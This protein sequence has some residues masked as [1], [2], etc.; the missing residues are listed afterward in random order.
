MP[1]PPPVAIAD[2]GPERKSHPG[3]WIAAAVA[4]LLL[5]SGAY[6]WFGPIRF[7]A[8]SDGAVPQRVAGVIKEFPVDTGATVA[9]PSIVVT[10][11]LRAKAAAHPAIPNS[12]PRSVTPALLAKAGTKMT[13]A[14][15]QESPTGPAVN[16]SVIEKDPQPAIGAR[17]IANQIAEGGGSSVRESEVAVQSPAGSTYKGWKL[18]SPTGETYVLDKQNAPVL[19]VIYSPDTAGN[20]IADRL[21]GNVGNGQGLLD[22]PD[23]R[24]AIMAVP[25]NPPGFELQDISTYNTADLLGPGLQAGLSQDMGTDVNQLS[26]T[27]QKVVPQRLT[28]ATYLDSAK[29]SWNVVVGNY[30]RQ[31]PALLAWYAIRAALAGSGTKVNP[32]AQ[33][34]LLLNTGDGTFA[35]AHQGGKIAVIKGKAG[36][37][38]ASLAALLQSLR[39]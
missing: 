5:G 24:D 3:R 2:A 38:P 14:R 36:S 34:S 22:Y 11:D 39:F 17:E 13:S 30:G 29:G 31:G 7:G 35:V 16:V 20:Q 25:P 15:Y 6:F 27:I 32:G 4:L 19:I 18:I 26:G 33:G 37:P 23:S 12:L 8:K 9:K 21:A 28:A 10:Q 1:L